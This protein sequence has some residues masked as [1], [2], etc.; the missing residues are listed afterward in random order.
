MTTIVQKIATFRYPPDKVAVR[1]KLEPL[2]KNTNTMQFFLERLGE[3]CL[4]KLPPSPAALL[5]RFHSFRKLKNEKSCCC[6]TFQVEVIRPQTGAVE[7]LYFPMPD[8]RMWRH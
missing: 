6:T 3:V 1:S 2:L 8:E 7:M 4:R 5:H